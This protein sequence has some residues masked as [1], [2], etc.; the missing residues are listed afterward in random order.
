MTNWCQSLA[1]VRNRSS[2][3]EWD[4]SHACASALRHQRRHRWAKRGCR[5]RYDT[6]LVGGSTHDHR[7]WRT[8]LRGCGCEPPIATTCCPAADPSGKNPRVGV[9]RRL[10]VHCCTN[11]NRV[12][13][14][15]EEAVSCR[16]YT[17]QRCHI[18]THNPL[19]RLVHM[20]RPTEQQT[21]SNVRM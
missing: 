21:K 14:V 20:P 1:G 8:A 9:E 17:Q 11:G 18:T 19:A 5:G 6:R 7:P 12:T 3:Y 15:V 10:A 4:A 16:A 13:R 2:V